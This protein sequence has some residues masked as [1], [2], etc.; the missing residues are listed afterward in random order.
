MGKRIQFTIPES[1][2]VFNYPEEY[3]S[4]MVV[5]TTSAPC[6]EGKKLLIALTNNPDVELYLRMKYMGC[7]MYIME[8]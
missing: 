2:E 7:E 8:Y 5:A 1:E 3:R 6:R 4:E